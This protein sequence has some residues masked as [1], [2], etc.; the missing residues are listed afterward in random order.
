MAG[1]GANRNDWPDKPGWYPD[2]WSATGS[3][4]RYFDGKRW[5]T[6]D[7]PLGRETVAEAQSSARP[8]RWRSLRTIV[9]V[10]LV[11][12]GAWFA[13]RSGR[14]RSTTLFAPRTTTTTI[15]LDRPP[16]SRE[17]AAHPL[18]T[19]VA[20]PQGTGGFEF[21][22]HQRIDPTAPVAFDACRP[23]HYVINSQGEP[24]DG[25][26]LIHDALAR[27]HAATGLQFISD[28]ATTE[29][30]SKE[31]PAFQPARYG[32]DRWAPVLIAWSDEASFPPLAGYIAGVATSDPQYT[33]SNRLA[34]VSG[35]VVLDGEQLSTA[36]DPNRAAVRAVILHELGHLVG[37]DH[38]AD[39]TEIMFSESDS[40]VTDYGPGDRRGLAI[41][42][43]Q[44]CDPDL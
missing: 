41:L 23:I 17:E 37:L 44:A 18:G 26:A 32:A 3:G 38:V 22:E 1:R 30:P 40:G 13:T 7:R 16:P 12:G 33:K 36:N 35:E 14:A 2:P 9:V 24:P 43:T 21:L 39:R 28:G 31:R 29:P 11:I 25:T 27:V 5:G 15:S 4:E 20:P 34:F 6:A 10:S 42:G 8:H 19:P